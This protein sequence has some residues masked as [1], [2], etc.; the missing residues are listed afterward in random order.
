[1]HLDVICREIRDEAI[2]E[3]WRVKLM[4]HDNLIR[5]GEDRR[6]RDALLRQACAVDLLLR[7][8]VQMPD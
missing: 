8:L 1:M 7:M 5:A 4:T 3:A 6:L 2:R